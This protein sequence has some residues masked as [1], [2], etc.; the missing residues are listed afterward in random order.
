MCDAKMRILSY[1]KQGCNTTHNAVRLEE[2]TPEKRQEIAGQSIH[3]ST[4]VCM[5]TNLDIL[6]MLPLPLFANI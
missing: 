3:T 5:F 6:F 1:G 4:K 2:E